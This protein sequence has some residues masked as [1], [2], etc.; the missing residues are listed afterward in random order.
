MS[1]TDATSNNETEL[2]CTTSDSLVNGNADVPSLGKHD[3][4]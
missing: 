2:T 4:Y 1:R 3:T